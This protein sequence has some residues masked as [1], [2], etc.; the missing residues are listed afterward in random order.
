M[1]RS[2]PKKLFSP[3]ALSYAGAVLALVLFE[4]I[5]GE[6]RAGK[7]IQFDQTVRQFVHGFAS[8]WMTLV[9]RAFTEIG[10]LVITLP[11][12]GILCLVLWFY[13]RRRGA[14]LLAVTLTGAVTLMYVLKLLFHRARPEAY[15]GY[16]SPRNFSFPSGHALGAFCFWGVLAV[17]LSTEAKT[18]SS[19]I[20]IWTVAV[21]MVAA[22]GLSRIY[23]GVHYPSDVAGGYLAGAVWVSGV[24]W[25]Y[26]HFRR[27]R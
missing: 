5:A 24:G 17:I 20:A 9:M 19:R 26:R 8:P 1:E 21:L 6:V 14:V 3:L 13:G 4:Q 16:A 27:T 22:I 12:T 7:T 10:T 23:L 15:F 25:A 11:A 18:V 2:F